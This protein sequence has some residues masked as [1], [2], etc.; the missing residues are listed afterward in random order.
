M[1]QLQVVKQRS[2]ESV[3]AVHQIM[4]TSRKQLIRNASGDPI[5]GGLQGKAMDESFLM[6]FVLM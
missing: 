5:D 2:D 6:P 3:D 1:K 4:W